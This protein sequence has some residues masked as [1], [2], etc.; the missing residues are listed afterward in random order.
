MISFPRVIFLTKVLID[1]SMKEW[2]EIVG[3]TSLLDI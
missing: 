3:G 1:L 2:A